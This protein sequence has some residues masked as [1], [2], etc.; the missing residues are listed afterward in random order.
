MK[1][2]FAEVRLPD[3]SLP[4]EPLLPDQFPEALQEVALV[5]LQLSKVA[6]PFET[7]VGEAESVTVG[8][9]PLFPPQEAPATGSRNTLICPRPTP[10]SNVVPI[11]NPP[12]QDNAMS[13]LA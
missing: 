10:P 6:S 2:L 9:G 13:M 5:V 7:V 1:V 11:Y 12:S 8:I 4:E 3:D